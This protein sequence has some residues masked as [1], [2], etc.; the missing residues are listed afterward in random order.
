MGLICHLFGHKYQEDGICTRCKTSRGS[1]GL[2]F[3][4]SKDKKGYI[5]TSF[6]SCRDEIITVP[7]QYKKLPVKEIGSRAFAGY[8][9]PCDVVLPESITHICC[10]AFADSAVHRVAFPDAPCTMEE[11]VFQACTGLEQICLP[12]AVDLIPSETFAGCTALT[13]VH[14][15]F[16]ILSVGKGAF[17]GCTS[18]RAFT[19]A[20]QD[21][22][23][24]SSALEG[25]CSL[26]SFC[27][28]NSMT[29]L[30]DRL[31]SGCASLTQ[32]A[33][34]DGLIRIGEAALSGCA[35]LTEIRFPDTLTCIGAQAFR[36]CIGIETIEFPS[37]LT[38]FV[39]NETEESDIF[40]GC[41]S[42][43][44][45]TLHPQFKH[46]PKGMFADC[47]ALTDIY[48][49]GKSPDW[50]AI[51][52]DDGW[53]AGSACYVVHCINGRIRKGS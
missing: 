52:K 46:Y 25:C 51:R 19:Y 9:I 35:G 45:V 33:L 18:L 39:S 48:F 30:P 31:L 47:T 8:D 6:G 44:S 11:G 41:T 22:S 16:E 28:P 24:D 40:R 49:N 2:K 34:P 14:L 15:P 27:L 38:D 36:D 5:L 7:K 13:E 37:S 1:Q 29:V 43:K 10:F 26:C 4:R 53:D 32:V 50:R 17:R 21:I 12:R 20:R 23:L 42:L 3:K